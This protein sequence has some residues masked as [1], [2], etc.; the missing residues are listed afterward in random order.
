M[1]CRYH[2]SF[3]FGKPAWLAVAVALSAAIACDQAKTTPVS[4]TK[5][6]SQA[7]LGVATTQVQA[8]TPAAS[9]NPVSTAA[10]APR[11]LCGG[12]LSSKGAEISGERMSRRVAEGERDLPEKMPLSSRYTWINFWAA[13]CVPC[14][15]E[16]PRL[17]EW[18][19]KL[20]AA[21]VGFRVVFVS[22]DD[23]ER[24]LTAFLAQQPQ[25]GLRRSYWLE[26]GTPRTDWLNKVSLKSAMELPAHLIVD[27]SA[28]VRCKIQGAIEDADYPQLL[29]L[30]QGSR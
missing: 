17:L 30:L 12:A 5:E 3:G 6:R 27:A 18:E 11:K 7:V 19:R 10:K 21:G 1:S 23:D 20:N 22:L 29:G 14:K 8:A 9:S 13:W 2:F 15:E 25:V 4:V 24:Q 28:K 26:E 16:I